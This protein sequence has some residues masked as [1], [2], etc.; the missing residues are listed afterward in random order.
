MDPA[1][2]GA[3]VLSALG[4][5]G[6]LVAAF[7]QQGARITALEAMVEKLH[8]DHLTCQ[9]QNGIL[10]GRI[11]ALEAEVSKLE[12]SQIRKRVEEDR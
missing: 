2:I 7:K 9:E 10:R 12:L 6:A 4:L 5:V 11:V 1:I 3:I 8:A